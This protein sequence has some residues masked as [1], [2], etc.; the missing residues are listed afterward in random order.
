MP[1]RILR[2]AVVDSTSE[3]AFAALAERTARDGDVHVAREQTAGRGRL[4]RRWESAAGE[5]LYASFVLLPP[6]P[7]PPA[8]LVTMAA[9]LAVLDAVRALGLARARLDWPNDVVV[10]DAKLAGILVET[11]GLDPAAPHY[12]VGVGLNVLQRA[13][14][15][16]LERERAVTSL[17]RAG[18]ETTV[19]AA[20]GALCEALPRRMAAARADRAALER[21]YLAAT[22]LCDACVEVEIAA[23]TERG[24]LVSLS[25]AEGLVVSGEAGPRRIPLEHVRGIARA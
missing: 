13:F 12:V 11:R 4:G 20:L 7:P 25:L 5:G 3:R 15:G 23:G 24:T 17:A 9:G 2:H 22:G 1:P 8:P 18:V 21:D 16:E 19:D 6:P 10:D 14:A